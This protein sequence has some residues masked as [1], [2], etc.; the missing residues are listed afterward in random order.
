MDV[1]ELEGSKVSFYFITHSTSR[2]DT[3]ENFDSPRMREIF[4]EVYRHGHEI[5]I[6]PSYNTFNHPENFNK[7]VAEFKRILDSESLSY[8]ALGTQRIL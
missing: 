8:E 3:P 5:G 6:H 1:N 7:T 2:L 4:R